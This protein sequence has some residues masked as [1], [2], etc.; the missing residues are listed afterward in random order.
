MAEE[1]RYDV[2][3][4]LSEIGVGDAPAE[5]LDDEH[6]DDIVDEV[7]DDGD[8]IDTIIDDLPADPASEE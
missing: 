4:I 8:V 7:T 2:A 5:T 1:K 6:V 3:D